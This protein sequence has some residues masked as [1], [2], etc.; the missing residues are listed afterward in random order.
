MSNYHFTPS[1]SYGIGEHSFVT[2]TNAFS[3]EE[4]PQLEKYCDSLELTNSVVGDNQTPTDETRISKVSWIN[5]NSDSSFLYDRLASVA[6]N[7]N[8]QFFKFNI[9]GFSE[10]IQYTVYDSSVNGHYTWHLDS[11][12]TNFAPRKLSMVLQLSSPENYE[13]GDLEIFTCKEPEKV[14]KERGLISMFPSFRLHRVT[15][16]T[17]GVRKS[18][19]V[20]ICGPSFV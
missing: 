5:Y 3:E 13:G 10:D 4:L 7:L 15:P 19:V 17:A 1:P 9:H 16:V 6:R 14:K 8:G 11:G 12:N 20:W 2:W 18:L